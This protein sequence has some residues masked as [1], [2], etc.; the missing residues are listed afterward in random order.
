MTINTKLKQSHYSN[1]N[2]QPIANK[3]KQTKAQLKELKK[4]ERSNP[5]Y[6]KY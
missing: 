6:Y 4:F 1:K 5:Y 2:K 3:L